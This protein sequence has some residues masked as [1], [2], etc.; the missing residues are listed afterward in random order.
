MSFIYSSPLVQTGSGGTVPAVRTVTFFPYSTILI[1]PSILSCV[2]VAGFLL[3]QPR[4]SNGGDNTTLLFAL[5]RNEYNLSCHW[6]TIAFN[7]LRH[8]K[9]RLQSYHRFPI[10][11]STSVAVL[12]QLRGCRDQ[13]FANFMVVVKPI[14]YIY[15]ISLSHT[16]SYSISTRKSQP[17]LGQS[18]V[19]LLQILMKRLTESIRLH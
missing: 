15:F 9:R 4:A 8:R 5:F 7:V 13:W 12:T 10:M 18:H 3:S 6:I 16:P 11:R 2:K 19:E 14:Y 1:V 17:L